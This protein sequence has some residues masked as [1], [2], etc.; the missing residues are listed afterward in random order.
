MPTTSKPKCYNPRHPERTLLYQTLAEH[1]ESWLELASA[2]QFD[3]QGDHRSPKP[4]V[5]K[6]F[7]KYLECGIFAHGFAR[8]RCGDCGHDFLVAFSCKG[9]GVCPSCNTRR[10]AETAAHLTDHV[11]PHLPVRQWVLSVPKRLRYFMQRDGAVLG[12]VLRIFLRV[13]AQTLQANSP[14]AQNPDKAAL[15]IGAIAFIHRFGSSLNEHV[16]FHVCAVDGVFE[17][18]A[19]E[20]AAD[21]HVQARAQAPDQARRPGVIFHPATGVTADAVTQAQASLRKRI[22]RAF[23]GRG[24]L[25]GFEAQ[26]MLAYRHSGF[27]VD[28]SVCI[29]A[30]DRAGLERLLRYCARPPFAMERLRKAGRELVYRCAKQHSEPG[31]N[32]HNKRGTQVDE[33]TLTPL[34]LIDRIAA[35]VPLPRTHRHRYFGVL[36]PNSPLRAAVTVM[37]QSAAA[38]PVQPAQMQ[39]EPATTGAGEGE[40]AFGVRNPLPTQTEPAQPVQPKRPAHYLWAVLIA[41]IYEV[42]PLLCP[43]CGGQMRIIAFITHSADIHQIL[44]HIGVQTEPPRITPARGPPLWDGADVPKGEGV[45]VEPDWDEAAQPAPDF[46]VD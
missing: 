9:R 34:E 18:V 38:Q 25:E 30:H 2:G 15:H 26:E 43:I 12:M 17:E 7:A 31:R 42:F 3:G 40:G 41:R 10:M 36:A 21:A 5:R 19:G 23:V 22:L 28:T 39:A 14:G 29:A 33:I 35:L 1:Y 4:Y 24:L 20:G 6:A 44:E 8:A 11:F 46:E 27:S 45:E 32:L 37:A 13:I 16:H